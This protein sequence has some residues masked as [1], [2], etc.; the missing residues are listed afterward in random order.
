MRSALAFSAL[1]AAAALSGVAHATTPSDLFGEVQ[2]ASTESIVP[3]DLRITRD[4]RLRA[5]IETTS[6]QADPF[7]DSE[8]PMRHRF[9]SSMIDYYPLGGAHGLRVSGGLRFYENAYF[10]RD[11]E[12]KTGGLLWAPQFRGGG[13]ALRG[14]YSRYTPAATVGYTG[15]IKNAVYGVEIGS[16]IGSATSMPSRESGLSNAPRSGLNPIANLMVGLRF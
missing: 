4:F 10:F 14:G 7:G 5:D 13:N 11:A 6:R 3:M 9:A 16:L 1:V 8:G 15:T 12:Q 2:A